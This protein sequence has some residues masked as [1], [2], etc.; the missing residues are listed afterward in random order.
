[1]AGL[2]Y[3]LQSMLKDGHKHLSG[4]EEAVMKNIEACKGLSQIARTSLGP[5]GEYA[6]L[7]PTGGDKIIRKI[8]ARQRFPALFRC[9]DE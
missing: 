9:R 3:G 2:P 7:A 6:D 5:N 1:M 4:L 8:A